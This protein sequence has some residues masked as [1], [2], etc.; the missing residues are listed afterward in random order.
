MEQIIKEAKK[1]FSGLGWCYIAGTLAVYGLQL[2]LSLVL[3]R[4]KPDWL[5]DGSITLIF[6]CILTY[7][8]AMPLIV[9]LSRG[10]PKSRIERHKM[11]WWQFVLALIMCYSLVYI[12]NFLGIM[13]TSVI[14][15]LKG[16]M[17]E[18]KVVEYVTGGNMFLNF[19]AMVVIAPVIEEYVFRKVIVDR[20]VRYGQGFAVIASGLMFG[21]FH[22]N[23]NQFAYAVVLGMF[24]AF[25][26][27]KTGNLKITIAMHAIVNF[28]GSMVGGLLMRMID[29]DELMALT[30]MNPYDTEG[31]LNLIMD[32]LAGW[33][34]LILY[35]MLLVAV[36]IAGIILCIVFFKRFRLD[37]GEVQIPTGRRFSVL[38]LNPGMIVFCVIWLILI[39]MQLFA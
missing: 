11:K 23:L 8:I 34:L 37:P 29:Y 9:L 22:G 24:F 38:F 39:V 26:Y 20:T 5:A 35:A 16:G 33:I 17:V 36:V 18:N 28:M 31:M 2:L 32:N 1:T 25:L 27:V 30:Q 10:I 12:C 19:I 15:V 14:G 21:L 3:M 13:I 4:L 6:S 7:G